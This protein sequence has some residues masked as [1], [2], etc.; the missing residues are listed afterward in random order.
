MYSDCPFRF[1]AYCT[2][3]LDVG[4]SGHEYDFRRIP[5]NNA[6]S[7]DFTGQLRYPERVSPLVSL[8]A[9]CADHL[10]TLV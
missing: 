1:S 4:H 2:H 7:N 3:R 6:S 8:I 9:I 5:G 10:L